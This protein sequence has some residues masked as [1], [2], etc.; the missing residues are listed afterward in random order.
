MEGLGIIVLIFVVIII[1]SWLLDKAVDGVF[2]GLVL[3]IS[4]P[5]KAAGAAR[6]KAKA[7]AFVNGLQFRTTTAPDV[8]H[9][10][11]AEHFA[12]GEFH[13]A[14]RVIL[15]TDEPGRFVVGFAW[16]EETRFNL[17]NGMTAPGSGL[18]VVV[19]ELTHDTTGP[20]TEGSVRLT[21]FSHDPDWIDKAV[22]ENSLP[23]ILDPILS[24]D[25]AASITKAPATQ[26]RI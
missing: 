15:Q 13:P 19:A 17:E 20:G 8:L 11:L 5:F 22:M 4:A 9:A 2:A 26:S 14:N 1:G 23:W 25:S 6:E 24:L 3:L 21:R 7:S 18:P 10:A 12:K 16:H